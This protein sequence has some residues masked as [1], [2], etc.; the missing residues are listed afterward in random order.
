M[1]STL[2]FQSVSLLSTCPTSFFVNKIPKR[3]RPVRS[4]NMS[5]NNHRSTSSLVYMSPIF[6]FFFPNPNPGNPRMLSKIISMQ[7]RHACM[8]QRMLKTLSGKMHIHRFQF[9]SVFPRRDAPRRGGVADLEAQ[10]LQLP[11]RVHVPRRPRGFLV[12]RPRARGAG[13][14]DV[15]PYA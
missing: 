3:S 15:A 2:A 14:G 5:K 8:R 7:K 11:F 13:V 4:S 10:P 9:D 1:I 6:S 12:A